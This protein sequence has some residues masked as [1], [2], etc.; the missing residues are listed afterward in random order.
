[1]HFAAGFACQPDPS[2]AELL[3]AG[4]VEFGLEVVKVTE[5]FLDHIGDR[6]SGIAPTFRLHDFPE[7][8]V[9]NVSAAIVADCATDI[10]R[11]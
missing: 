4:I 8:G 3:G 10:F 2:A 6:A 5:R 9:I 7:H 1:M 11:N